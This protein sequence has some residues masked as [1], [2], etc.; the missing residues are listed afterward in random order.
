MKKKNKG[1]RT[2]LT[3]AVLLVLVIA[4]AWMLKVRSE[5]RAQAAAEALAQAQ[6]EAAQAEAEALAQAQEEAAQAEQE[7]QAQAEQEAAEAAA[8]EAAQAAQEQQAADAEQAKA[9]YLS[10]YDSAPLL[11][12]TPIRDLSLNIGAAEDEVRLNW[13]SPDGNPGKVS[14]YTIQNGDFQMVDAECTASATVPGYYVNKAVVTGIEPGRTYA[15]KVGNDTGGWSPEYKYAVPDVNTDEGFTFLVTSDVEIGQDHEQEMQVTV[16]DWDKAVTRLTNYVP[17]AQFLVHAGDQVSEFGSE[18]QYAGFLDHLA[19]YK[20]PLVPVVGNHDVANEDMVEKLGYP[21]GPYFSEHFNVPNRSDAYGI[22]GGDQTGDYYFIRGDALFIVLNSCTDQQ[23]DIHEE[24]VPQVIA[25]HPDTKWRIIIQ[26][27]P[28]YSG[29]QK[30]QESLD[31][32]IASSL[33][34]ICAD[35]DI[36]LVI[37]G[38]DAAYSRSAFT[39]RKCQV[40]EG[41]DYSSGAV[42]V[43]PEGTMHVTCSTASGSIY[44]DASPNEKLVFQGQPYAPVALRFD[45][46]DTE[47]HLTAYLIDS[48]TVYDEYTIQK[49]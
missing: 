41:Y 16:E 1:V 48:W 38:H 2:L 39:D 11:S 20:I 4:A 10:D 7:A 14:W 26:H 13:M 43:N 31:P 25:Q 42:A 33:A 18:E 6:E 40:Y 28:P 35:N 36:D 19:L 9:S 5:V 32:W 15:Y 12:T 8:E 44:R 23:T 34:Y 49:T 27:Y 45:V 3:S 47:L 22:N 29:V 17:E 21:A 46:T 24:Y 37:S 30:Y